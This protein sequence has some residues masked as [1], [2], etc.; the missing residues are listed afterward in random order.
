MLQYLPGRGIVRFQG[1]GHGEVFMSVGNIL[2][3]PIGNCP[4]EI[5][6]MPTLPRNGLWVGQDIPSLGEPA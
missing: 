1:G 3:R 4:V 6:H 2:Q 5:G